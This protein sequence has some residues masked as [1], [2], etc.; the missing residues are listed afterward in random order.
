ME[1]RFDRA[2]YMELAA[3]DFSKE[4]SR[5]VIQSLVGTIFA[6]LDENEALRRQNEVLTLRVEK[7]EKDN[8]ELREE[9][10]ELKIRLDKDGNNSSKPPSTDGLKKPP[11]VY[12]NSM[13]NF[14]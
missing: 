7:L 12:K 1:Q 9:V 4:E 13:K 2:K 8:R 5:G 14:S 11:I 3:G 6:L 10:R